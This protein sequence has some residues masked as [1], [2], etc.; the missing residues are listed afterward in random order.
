MKYNYYFNEILVNVDNV[1]VVL[2]LLIPCFKY[3]PL[4]TGALCW[5]LLWY[6]IF[7]GTFLKLQST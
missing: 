6:A 5:F 1:F 7:C 4:F 3:I 2:L